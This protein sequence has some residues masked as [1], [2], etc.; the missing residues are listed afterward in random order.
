MLSLVIRNAN[1]V[2]GTGKPAF[3]GDLGVVGDRIAAVG[4]VEGSGEVEIDAKG[5]TLAPGFIDIHTHYDPQLCWDRNATPTPEHGVSSLVM[6]NCSIS[7]SPVR[8]GDRQRLMH[9]FG[10]V[11]DMEGRKRRC[12]FPGKACPII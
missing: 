8:A 7:L 3:R 10:S 9:L 12:R 2:D 5:K 4:A 1:I 11:E 6:G